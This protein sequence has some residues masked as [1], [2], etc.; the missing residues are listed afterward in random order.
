VIATAGALATNT[1][2]G[3]AFDAV[4]ARIDDGACLAPVVQ[5]GAAPA[6]RTAT[7]SGAS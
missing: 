6:S 1:M 3:K 4:G 7:A 2:T 5:V